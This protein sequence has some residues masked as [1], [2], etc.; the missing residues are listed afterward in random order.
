MN[1]RVR[2]GLQI[3][4]ANRSF[5]RDVLYITEQASPTFVWLQS[6][7]PQLYGSEFVEDDATMS[8]MQRY[9]DH[10]GGRG[11][12]RFEDV[13]RLKFRDESI[14]AVA[15]FDVLEHVPNYS[16]ALR[17]FARVLNQ[18]GM[19]VLTVPFISSRQDTLVR[20]QVGGGGEIEY[21][22]EPEYHGDPRSSEGILCFYHFGWDLLDAA[23]EAGFRNA[24]MA[25]PWLPG[26]GFMDHLWTM[27]A[28]R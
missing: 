16:A 15:S 23:R 24:Y 26:M 12:I 1:A 10:L 21:L 5:E 20:A 27:V 3:L 7:V 13:T 17:E 19:L 2:A 9:F 25:K 22:M 14:D 18:D 8:D 4:N 6:R 28:T 11:E